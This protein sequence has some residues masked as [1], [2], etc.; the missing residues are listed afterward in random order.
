MHFTSALSGQEA[1]PEERGDEGL[2]TV[3]RLPDQSD[4][5]FAKHPLPLLF[6]TARLD[7]VARIRLQPVELNREV[8]HLAHERQRAVRHDRSTGADL[9]Q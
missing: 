4:F 3:E 8:E 2:F 6:L 1:D 7:H 9:V 5:I